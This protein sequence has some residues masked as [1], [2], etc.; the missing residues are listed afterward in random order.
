MTTADVVVVGGGIAGLAAAWELA[1]GSPSRRVVL[2]EA[3][4]RLGGKVQTSAFAGLALDAGP[5]AFL[6]RVPAAAQLAREVGLGDDLV[7]PGTGHAWLWARGRLRRLP[8]GL[9]LGV[10]VDFAALARSRVLP[11]A[12]TA[13]AA[14]DPL[15]PGRPVGPDDDVSVG[16]LVRR[17]MGRGVQLDLVDPLLG[18]INAGHTDGLSAAVAAPQLLAAARREASLVRALR[19]SGTG[20]TA[21]GAVVQGPPGA[22]RRAGAGSD[23]AGL[24]VAHER[25]ASPVFL[26]VRGGLGRLVG[27]LADGLV[28]RGATVR[29]GTAVTG[30]DRTAEG[31][32]VRFRS[33]RPAAGGGGGD[34]AGGGDGDGAVDA[35]AVVVAC[36]AVALVTAVSP[37]AGVQLGA[38]E[39]ASVALVSLAYRN[40]DAPHWDGSG[41]LVPRREGRFVTAASW[42]GQKWPHLAVPGVVTV[43]ASAGRVDDTRPDELDD[44]ELVAAV[45]ADLVASMGLRA[46]PIEARVSRWRHAFPQYGVG[47]LGRV[48]RMERQLAEDAPGV[49]LAGAALRG[50]GLATCIAG[51]R[52]AAAAARAYLDAVR[53]GR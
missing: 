20:G 33:P 30:L 40:A 37:G 23:M 1:T 29:T 9:V 52:A 35:G 4:D 14:L 27:A 25:E 51:G 42:V 32:R 53:A 45:H 49:V 5:D 38:I 17:R 34:G 2:L 18:G 19:T 44:D 41:F 39:W 7:A 3:E 6:A 47:H 43:R 31:W 12:A 48:E 10:P 50:V 26:T 8:T 28:A 24:S 15:L 13:R 22:G 16:W 11:V 21:S 46:G 36:P